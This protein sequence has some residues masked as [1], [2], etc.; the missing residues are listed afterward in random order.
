MEKTTGSRKRAEGAPVTLTAGAG[1][2]TLSQD[3]EK[4]G[5]ELRLA[6]D[7]T[8]KESQSFLMESP[9]LQKSEVRRD[10]DASFTFWLSSDDGAQ[11]GRFR[12]KPFEL[13]GFGSNPS[14]LARLAGDLR[15]FLH[16]EDC[17]TT[18][19]LALVLDLGGR[20]DSTPR[21]R[22]RFLGAGT[23]DQ[24]GRRSDEPT[25]LSG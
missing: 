16:S 12:S 15:S 21:M 23:R 11:L 6:Q 8:G 14:H 2:N 20:R 25:I 17:L 24:A 4:S 5:I 10:V 22:K 1:E 19:R 18:R 13:G 7:R 3:P 9:L